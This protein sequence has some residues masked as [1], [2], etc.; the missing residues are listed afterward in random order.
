MSTTLKL[1]KA[2]GKV[3]EA[4]LAAGLTKKSMQMYKSY[5]FTPIIRF[6]EQKKRVHYSEKITDKFVIMLRKQY[7]NEEIC[8]CKF[9][10]IRKVTEMLKELN[11]TGT[12]SWHN[13]TPWNTSKLPEP[14]ADYLRR[15]EEEKISLGYRETTMRGYKP[16]IK[17]FLLYVYSLGFKDLTTLTR[18]QIAGYIPLLS[19]SYV[20]AGH[21][22]SKLRSFGEFLSR[23][24]L[25]KVDMVSVLQIPIPS[26]KKY[27]FGFTKEEAN[28]IIS[29]INR[30]SAC[31]KRDYAILMLAKYTG[32]RAIDVLNLQLN[33]ID[34]HNYEIKIVQKKTDRPLVLPLE[35]CVCNAIADYILNGRPDVDSQYVFLRTRSPHKKLESWSGYSIVKR[36][37][38]EVGITWTASDHKGFHSFRR[39]L[40]SWMLESEIPLSTIS[41]ILGHSH[42]DSTKPY[43]ATHTA[44]LGECAMT[45]CGIETVREELL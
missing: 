19:K 31:G 25:I 5:G 14:F 9:Q 39:S 22:L 34:W 18:K 44:M 16:V 1:S 8:I 7:E 13:V 43:I 33:E 42:T 23:N 26:R 41:E 12:T 17:H 27:A 45:L 35:T 10:H 37:A 4:L 3:E 15:Y 2:I 20:R 21:C 32:L 30:D 40:G 24:N 38:A 11:Q 6:Y 29:A 36:K 28:Q